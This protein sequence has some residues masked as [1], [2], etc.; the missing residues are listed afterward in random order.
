MNILYIYQI[1]LPPG[2]GDMEKM[3]VGKKMKKRRKKKEK[4]G[5]KGGEK[6]GKKEGEMGKINENMGKNRFFSYFFPKH[7]QIFI[8]FSPN[9]IIMGKNMKIC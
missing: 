1:I 3:A 8:F 4:K 2:G 6:E 7:L 5:E 9:D